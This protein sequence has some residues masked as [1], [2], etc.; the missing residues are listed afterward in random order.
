MD[1][2]KLHLKERKCDRCKKKYK[3]YIILLC[4]CPDCFVKL[5]LINSI[6][7]RHLCEKCR[8]EVDF[9]FTKKDFEKL[10]RRLNEK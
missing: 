5:M 3:G 2:Q 8:K 1:K 10:N 6:Y 4:D 7:G 9:P